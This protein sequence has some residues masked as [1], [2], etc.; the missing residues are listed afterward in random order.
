VGLT[1]AKGFKRWDASVPGGKLDVQQ[2]Q[3]R[4]ENRKQAEKPT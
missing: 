2:Q 3:H 4:Q 1:C